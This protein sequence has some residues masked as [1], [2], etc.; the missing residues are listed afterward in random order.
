MAAI[1][2]L[3][4][5]LLLSDA[6]SCSVIRDLKEKKLK[7]SKTIRKIHCQST[8]MASESEE[9]EEY[10]YSSEEDG[11]PVDDEETSMEWESDNPN[12][13]PMELKGKHQVQNEG[14]ST[15]D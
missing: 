4:T 2:L 6:L 3:E 14:N 9:Y 1:V 10:A 11:Y 15:R 8:T 7:A 5:F 13:A 12:A